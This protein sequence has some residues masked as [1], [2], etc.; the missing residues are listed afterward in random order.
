MLDLVPL[1]GSRRE[2]ADVDREAELVREPLQFVL[3][4]VR[5]IAVAAARV[6]GDEQVSRL[7]VA[8]AAHL[9][10]PR[11]DRG[12]RED[13]RVVV[14]ADVDEAVVGRNVIDAVGDGLADRVVGEVVHV[15]HLR[16]ALGL[17]LAS[18][19]SEV[20]DQ[21]FLLRVDGDER[22]AA[23]EALLCLRVEVLELRVAVRVLRALDGLDRCLQTVFVLPQQLAHRLVA[24]L[25]PVLRGQLR[26]QNP[27]ALAGPSQRRFRVAP[28]DRIDE[29]LKRRPHLSVGSLKRALPGAAPSANQALRPCPRAHLVTSLPHRADRHPGRPRHEG[30]STPAKSVRLGAHPQPPHALIHRG[31]EPLPL[32]ANL[33]FDVHPNRRSRIGDPVDLLALSLPCQ[34]DPLVHS[35]ALSVIGGGAFGLR[36]VNNVFGCWLQDMTAA[37]VTDG[38]YVGTAGGTTVTHYDY[39]RQATNANQATGHG[40]INPRTGMADPVFVCTDPPPALCD[41]PAPISAILPLL[42]ASPRPS[43]VGGDTVCSAEIPIDVAS[44]PLG[45]LRT[46]KDVDSPSE[47]VEVVH[48]GYPRTPNGLNHA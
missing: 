38:T 19:V 8:L 18:A 28:R 2:V 47:A 22:H 41:N 23:F 3:P 12:D 9:L 14:D 37:P 25:D 20:A 29:L 13:R 35:R 7:G 11:R 45:V 5:P 1:A 26:R 33:L 30:D 32:R 4:D 40:L 39:R 6:G 31:P 21:L 17:P 24:N 48:I 42:D 44:S 34:I 10:P 36:G 43:G 46:Y 16:F 15:H 27:C